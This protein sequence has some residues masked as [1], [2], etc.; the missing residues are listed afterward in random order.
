M[1]V[2][3]AEGKVNCSAVN[4]V[5]HSKETAVG[6]VVVVAVVV[7]VEAASDSKVVD[8]KLV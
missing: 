2:V 5:D 6:V 1:E 4:T 3:V 8:L 7:V